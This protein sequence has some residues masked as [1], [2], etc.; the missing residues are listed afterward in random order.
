IFGDYKVNASSRLLL[1]PVSFHK[2]RKIGEVMNA[3]DRAGEG[4]YSITKQVVIAL[5][6]KFF[7]IIVGFGF[8]FYMNTLLALVLLIGIASYVLVIARLVPKAIPL[9]RE[10]NKRYGKAYG[11][12]YDA[13]GNIAI[14]K[15]FVAE[16]FE[17]T[18]IKNSFGQANKFYVA[19]THVWSNL[20]SSS[21]AIV[22]VTQLVIFILSV[23]AIQAEMMTLGE[24]L[25]F[26]AYAAMVFG[27]FLI[28]GQ[29]WQTL[30]NGLVALEHAESILSTPTEE[31]TP[32]NVLSP[33]EKRGAIEFKNVSFAYKKGNQVLSDVSFV[34]S[35]GQ[36]VALVGES[37]A[38]KSTLI[39]LIS[40]YYF[41]TKGNVIIDGV[42]TDK[43]NLKELRQMIAI[44]PQEVALFNDT[45]AKNLSY[46]SKNYS[47]Q[48]IKGAVENAHADQF[49]EKMP[50]KY[51]Q[52]VGERGVKLSVGQKQRI[53]IARAILRNPKILILDEPTS[54]L[55]SETEKFVT[56]ALSRVMSGRTTFVI[57]HRLSTVRRANKIL[58][59][60][61]GRIAETGT[62]DELMAIDN[63]IYRHRYELHAGL[64]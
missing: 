27:P 35:P 57:A 51:S 17:K 28:L 41:P 42:S 10:I 43:W 5:A 38:G 63:G 4:V 24:L 39:D 33:K 48:E 59:L 7:S 26:N 3:I 30:Q 54:A 29:N 12:A 25:A 47:E 6:P 53:A 1:L 52:V 56:D 11:L 15:Q 58:V 32:K 14:V 8:A 22:F 31:Y 2:E 61:N 34:A 18:R 19:L 13:I 21:R 9:D 64:V 40:A 60:E 62:H 50:N 16:I 55:D 36:I 46:G 37:G 44:V 45:I 20:S 23:F 49:I